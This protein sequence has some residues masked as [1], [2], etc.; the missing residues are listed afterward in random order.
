MLIGRARRRHVTS[1][2]S[3]PA[4]GIQKCRACSRKPRAFGIVG[5]A[6]GRAEPPAPASS[7]T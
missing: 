3:I 1:M 4:H 2:I 6:T 5:G 7:R